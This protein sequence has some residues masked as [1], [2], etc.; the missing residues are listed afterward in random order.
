MRPSWSS[1][2]NWNDEL[3]EHVQIHD[4][5]NSRLHEKEGAVHTFFAENA[6]HLR[7]VANMFQE[8]TWIFAA[9]DPTAVGTDL[10]TDMRRALITE[11]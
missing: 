6:K 10:T 11:N 9:P 1:S 8:D 2:S 4:T 5:G 3:L 7:A